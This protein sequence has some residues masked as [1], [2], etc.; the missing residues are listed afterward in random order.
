MASVRVG[1]R[2]ARFV[3][4]AG[5]VGVVASFV[6][7]TDAQARGHRRPHVNRSGGYAPPF[8]AMVVDA[9]TGK[10]M[11]GVDVDAPRHPASITKVMTLYLLFEQLERGTITLDTDLRISAHA[12]AQSPSKLGLRPGATI[13][14]EDAIKAVVTKSANDIAVAIAEN[15]GGSEEDFAERMTRKARQLGMTGTVYR[16]ASGLPNSEQITTARDLTIL[17]RAIQEKFPRYYRYFQTRSFQFAGQSIGNHNRLLGRVEGVDGIKTGFTNA[18][19][20]NLMTSARIDGRRVV[21]VILG[22]RSGASRDNQMAGLM[23]T[24]LPRAYAG[25]PTSSVVADAGERQRPPAREPARTRS[26]D[27]ETTA[28]T[29]PEPP[30]S[31]PNRGTETSMRAV[32]ASAPGGS[33]TTP[34]NM[35]WTT[36]PAGVPQSA[37]VYAS[38]S[39]ADIVPMPPPAGQKIEARLP[40]AQP[41]PEPPSRE[42]AAAVRAER[43]AKLETE[44]EKR[45]E[46]PVRDLPKEAVKP[47]PG[48]WVIQLGAAEDED[49]ARAILAEARSRS[50]R[51]LA[52]TK[53]YTE[54]VV[55]DG[56]TLYRAR[57]SGFEEPDEAQEACKTLKSRGFA[58]FATRS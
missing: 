41:V 50:G 17:A 31:R 29:T 49:K 39:P 10:T 28:A 58:C 1:V 4:L 22:G 56:S 2:R 15:V 51:A 23:R 37:Q 53:P 14:V 44:P 26:V 48:S 42:I 12:A 20:F 34:S 18:S 25:S 52:D 8:S 36:G 38:A 6:T 55:R 54:K 30:P 32:V 47:R 21:A 9:N 35:K 7:P 24:Y 33:A 46:P 19:G 3:V 40:T 16:N 43:Y 11:Y 45:P 13:S 5:V 57:F 27:V